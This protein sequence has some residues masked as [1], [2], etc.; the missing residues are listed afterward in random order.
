MIIE[1]PQVGESV[2]EGVIGKWMIQVG[3]SV[4][5]YDPLVEVITDKVTMELPSPVS[6]VL[7]SILASEGTTVLMGAPIAE[8]EVE[9]IDPEL[10]ADSLNTSNVNRIGELL[11]DV[12]PVGPTGAGNAPVISRSGQ[13]S[14]DNRELY[15][16]AVL[17]LARDHGVDLGL[18]EGT[19]IGGRIRRDDLQRFIDQ[20]RAN[21]GAFQGIQSDDEI[22]DPI[23]E[24]R[25]LTPLR[26]MIAD[27]MAKSA[28]EIPQAWTLI[29][30]D[31]S[32]LVELRL[33]VQSEFEKKEGINLTYLPFVVKVVAECLKENPLLNS[34][35]SGTYI[36]LKKQINIGLAAAA[37]EGLV[38]PVIHDAD[39]L[40]LPALAQKVFDL[41]SRARRGQLRL[42][43]VHGGTFTLNN[44]GVLGSI[45]S[46]PLINYPQAA[47]LTTEAIVK[48][49]MVID[50]VIAIRSMMNL[51]LSFDHRVIDG[52]EASAFVSRVKNRLETI[53]A[54]IG[55]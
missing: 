44:T 48:R 23:E 16:P 38:V 15:S 32:Q 24:R 55:I 42:E 43:D 9:G 28:T 1:L 7:T 6:G 34:S 41:T 17:R 10:F 50:D 53:E 45:A 31:V 22:G 52:S 29:E 4:E 36:T 14:K 20:D 39:T 51:C 25:P 47:I 2:T 27:R 37:P 33:A 35:W 12:A 54:D 21:L 3:Q 5:K 11:T 30:V 26:R 13:K 40:S 46:K 18:V 8:M 19:G 49:P